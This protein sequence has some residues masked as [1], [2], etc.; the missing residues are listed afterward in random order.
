MPTWIAWPSPASEPT[1]SPNTAPI[2]ATAT[3]TFAPEK[4][5]GSAAGSSR[6]RS[7]AQRH[8][9]ERAQ[10][11][12]LRRVDGAQAVERVDDDREEADEGDH[13]QLRRDA[14]PEPDHE[15][16][17]DHDHRHGL[18]GDD[19]RI[20][21]APQEPERCSAIAIA[22]PTASASAKPSSTSWAVTQASASSSVAVVDQRPG[23]LA[24]RGQQVVLDPARAR[25]DLPARRRAPPAERRRQSRR[26]G[27]ARLMPAPPAP[28]RGAR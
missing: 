24:G 4:R 6:R 8:A 28:A 11:L 5:Y 25:R 22:T 26:G 9:P 27:H 2:T 3:A 18:R 21:G 12:H 19:E 10:H 20:D 7:S 23:D 1:S 14:E 15:D 17:S 16:R 13:D